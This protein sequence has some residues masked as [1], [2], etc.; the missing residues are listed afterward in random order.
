MPGVA[1][2]SGSLS[3]V[4]VGQQTFVKDCADPGERPGP[5]G[6]P[7]C[8]RGSGSR[9]GA[10]PEVVQPRLHSSC[11]S[12]ANAST[13]S[14]LHRGA[15]A[16][17]QFLADAVISESGP[18][19][20]CSGPRTPTGTSIPTALP[21]TPVVPGP[22]VVE[23]RVGQLDPGLPASPVT[24]LDLHRGQN[25]LIM[26]LSKQS[27]L[28]RGHQPGRAG[29]VGRSMSE[30]HPAIG[31]DHYAGAGAAGIDSHAQRA[32]YQGPGRAGVDRP[33]HDAP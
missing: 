15:G 31:V 11:G 30:P 16:A 27:A 24:L 22:Q 26:A 1:C 32:G 28:H 18:R 13:S 20:S 10:G 5:R 12:W 17:R 8:R 33:T 23:D 6:R 4:A 14:A 25:D 29:A 7:P 9:D 3:G 19:R 21:A 2:P